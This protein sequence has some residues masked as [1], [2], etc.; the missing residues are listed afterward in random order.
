[1]ADRQVPYIIVVDAR[2]AAVPGWRQIKILAEGA[3][4]HRER[5]ALYPRG[6]ATISKNL[7]LRHTITALNCLSAPSAPNRF[8][9]NE[10]GA[11]LWAA[12]QLRWSEDCA[13]LSGLP[14]HDHPEVALVA[15]QARTPAGP[16]MLSS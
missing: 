3:R 6:T 5:W 8:F 13:G 2:N 9:A 7:L 1:M 12:E 4:L 10:S 11:E 16:T 14:E 15:L